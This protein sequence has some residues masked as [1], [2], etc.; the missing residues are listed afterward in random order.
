MAPVKYYASCSF[1]Y[2]GM[3]TSLSHSLNRWVERLGREY[4]VKFRSS[5]AMGVPPPEFFEEALSVFAEDSVQ[6]RYRLQRD[7][8]AG[9]GSLFI[10]NPEI[11][12]EFSKNEL[13]F[14]LGENARGLFRYAAEV[15]HSLVAM[16]AAFGAE[17]GQVEADDF[18]DEESSRKYQLFQEI[19]DIRV[20]VS[21][22]WVNVFRSDL[23]GRFG[24]DF[25]VLA[26][27]PDVEFGSES[28]YH[29]LVLGAR[30]FSY[31]VPECVEIQRD[32]ERLLELRV[33]QTIATR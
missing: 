5:A 29:W 31:R 25:N 9:K 33:L 8:D 12:G 20:P 6:M 2:H 14:S 22:E 26:S 15:R 23:V 17:F 4:F 13:E 27:L 18:S 3:P 1:E 7:D 28:G 10:A 19:R 21:I 11:P 16:A 24:W 32:V 30:P